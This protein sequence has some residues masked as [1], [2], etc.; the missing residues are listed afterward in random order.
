MIKGSMKARS[1]LFAKFSGGIV[2]F[3][4]LHVENAGWRRRRYVLPSS[5]GVVGYLDHVKYG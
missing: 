2:L 4:G 1:S 3:F 5:G